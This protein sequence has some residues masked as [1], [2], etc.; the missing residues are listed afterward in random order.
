MKYPSFTNVSVDENRISASFTVENIDWCKG[1]FN[2]IAILP[3]VAQMS[4]VVELLSCYKNIKINDILSS[5][6]Y[7]KFTRP[8]IESCNVEIKIE[9]F[10]DNGQ[11]KFSFCD[12]N[13]LNIQYSEGKFKYK[14]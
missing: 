14:L 6:D 4:F 10:S 3:G 1:H 12:S 9:I 13:D 5:I 8:I 11:I 2:S 7:V